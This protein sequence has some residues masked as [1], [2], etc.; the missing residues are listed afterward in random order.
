MDEKRNIK[1]GYVLKGYYTI[2]IL[3]GV[4]GFIMSLVLMFINTRAGLI[5]GAFYIVVLVAALVY[6]AASHRKLMEN[7][8]RFARSY[9]SIESELIAEFPLPYAI[10]DMDGNIIVYNDM[11]KKFCDEAPGKKNICSLFHELNEE[12]IKFEEEKKDYSAVYDNRNLRLHFKKMDIDKELFEKRFISYAFPEGKVLSLYLFDETE[13]VN[14]VKQSVA[15]QIV[16][17]SICI[18]NYDETLEHSTDIKKSLMVAMVD[19]AVDTYFNNIGGIVRKLDDDRYFAAFKRKYLGNLQR[20]RFELLDTVKEIET[21]GDMS[22][23]LSIGVGV[24][25]D[26]TK[27]SESA[28]RALELAL[29]RGGDQAVVRDGERV[30]YYGGKTRQAEKNS[31]VKA[32]LNAMA[33][34]EVFLNKD[35][36]VVMGHRVCDIDCLGAAIGIYRAARALGKNAHIILNDLTNTV[37]PILDNFE[38]DGEYD[39]VFIYPDEAKQYVDEDTALVVVDV[40]NPDYFEIPELVHLTSGII[41]IDHHLQSGDKMDSVSLFYHEPTA[42]SASEMV[43]EVLQYISDDLKLKKIEAE[44]LYAGILIDTNYFSKNTGVRT[45]EAAAYL[46]KNG[47]DVTKVKE[48]FNDSMDDFKAKAETVRSAEIIEGRFAVA[49]CP[50]DNI[51]NPTVVAAQVANELLDVNGITGSFVLA[52]VN[53]KVYVSA[54]SKG[55]INVQ[56]VMERLGGGGHMNTA[57]AQ[58]E[59]STVEETKKN[60]GLTIRK[61]VEEEAL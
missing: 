35:R 49:V 46:R 19:R 23:T 58:I 8:I 17:A 39:D 57:G 13:I 59:G 7:L 38:E 40:N 18:D 61:M 56:K 12:D 22:I 41:I 52:D 15:D 55:Y 6:T 21:E 31:R 28:G 48:L 26:I 51:D 9:E 37:R 45:F 14:M 20:G 24:G 10:M 30:Y 36:V 44:A 54:R 42:S 32:R 1:T 29:G 50:T 53:G 33:L 5:A 47:V 34:K 11:F 2:L 27:S 43:A 60:L 4:L 16:I 25:T 3:I